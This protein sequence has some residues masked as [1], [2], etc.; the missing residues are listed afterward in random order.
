MFFVHTPNQAA[1]TNNSCGVI[2]AALDNNPIP[3]PPLGF[4]FVP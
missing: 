1:R 3:S 4:Y 2:L